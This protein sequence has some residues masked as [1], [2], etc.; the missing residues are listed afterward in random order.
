MKKSEAWILVFLASADSIHKYRMYMAT[1]SGTD[2]GYVG[3][4][5]L[6]LQA[7]HWIKR[8][9]SLHKTKV[10]YELTQLGNEQVGLAKK[11]LMS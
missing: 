3:R 1:K 9:R 2:Y 6:Q 11:K 7:K 5:L 10:F 8:V 4:I